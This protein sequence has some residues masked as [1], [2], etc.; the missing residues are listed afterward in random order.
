[1]LLVGVAQNR[2][3]YLHAV[4]EILNVSNRMDGDPVSTCTRRENGERVRRVLAFY[5]AD[6]T[7]DVSERFPKY[8]TAFR[9][10][11]CITD[12]FVGNAPVQLCDARKMKETIALIYRNSNGADPLASE[13]SI[14]Q[15]W[16]CV[17]G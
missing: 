13:G 17:N 5:Q 16:Y 8:D 6:F 9:Y 12:G 2:N 10:H 14:P 1:M 15:K 11:R 4:E 3:T 7:H